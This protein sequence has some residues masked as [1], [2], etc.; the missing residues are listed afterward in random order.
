MATIVEWFDTAEPALM[1]CDVSAEIAQL[2]RICS[3]PHV[4]VLQHGDRGDAGHQAAYDGAVGILAPFHTDLSQTDWTPALRAKTCFAAGLG[5]DQVVL[6]RGSAR[7]RIGVP[8]Y[9][10]VILV[11]AGGGG[12]GF[13]QAPIGL[14]ARSRPGARWITIGPV[15]RDWH[16]TE[17]SNVE[18]RGW[19]ANPA[20]YIAA[21]DLVISSTGNTTCQQ[22]LRAARPW[23]AIPEWRYFDEQHFKAGALSVAGAASVLSHLPSS[24]A[25]WAR[26][27]S[28]TYAGHR[29]ERQ[30]TLIED[31]PAEKA[32]QWLES[33]AAGLWLPASPV[34]AVDE[35]IV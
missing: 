6:D 30:L 2:A 8:K 25:A 9:G 16:A 13:S 24:A 35:R 33:L 4:M 5:V 7:E 3:V 26:A 32:A 15:Q 18:H 1:V 27:I 22:V 20:D 12:S 29:Q 17:P 21:A 28:N 34:S 19:V 23:L 10:E 31:A 11:M 14:G